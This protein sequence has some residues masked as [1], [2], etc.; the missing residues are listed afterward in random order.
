MGHFSPFGAEKNAAKPHF[1][2]DDYLYCL[3]GL[4]DSL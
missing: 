3:K 1:I 2:S 4:T